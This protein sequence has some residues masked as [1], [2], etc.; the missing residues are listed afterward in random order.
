MKTICLNCVLSILHR[1]CFYLLGSLLYITVEADIT[2]NKQCIPSCIFLP[3]NLMCKSTPG[4]LLNTI[5]SQMLCTIFCSRKSLEI[6]GN[7]Y[8][9]E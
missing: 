6:E 8:L 3:R 4:L 5:V 7:I 1:R 2:P 9:Y